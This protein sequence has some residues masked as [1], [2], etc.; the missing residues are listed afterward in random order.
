MNTGQS[1]PLPSLVLLSLFKHRMEN[2]QSRAAW[3]R[4]WGGKPQISPLICSEAGRLSE[5]PGCNWDGGCPRMSPG[6]GVEE[7]DIPPSLLHWWRVLLKAEYERIYT[8][9]GVAVAFSTA[10]RHKGNC[11]ICPCSAAKTPFHKTSSY[12]MLKICLLQTVSEAW[13]FTVRLMLSA[14]YL[15]NTLQ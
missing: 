2:K 10:Q 14:R 6:G 15:G 7:Q 11:L 1:I 8:D 13:L 12:P 4:S 5:D 9:C 3:S